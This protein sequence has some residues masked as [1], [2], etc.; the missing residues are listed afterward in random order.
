MN[1]KEIKLYTV[2]NAHRGPELADAAGEVRRALDRL[3]IGRGL[4]R[5]IEP[6]DRVAIAV[7]SRGIDR[8]SE[9]LSAL[10]DH[11]GA[12]GGSPFIVPAMGSHGGATSAGQAALLEKLGIRP[13]TV[14]A[15]VESSIETVK[16]GPAP[17]GLRLHFDKTAHGADHV[18]LVNRVKP[19]TRFAGPIQSG[20]CK[21][22]LVGLGNRAGAQELHQEAM[23]RP[24]EV[25]VA[26]AL[27]RLADRTPLAFGLG[28]V[29]NS[30]KRL[31]ALRAV[32]AADFE[33]ADRELLHLAD[34]WMAR[35]P[36]GRIDILVVDRIGKE[37]SG[38]GM[39]TNVIGRKE[40]RDAPRVLRILVRGLTRASR[41]NATG[42]GFAD[43]MIRPC[44]DSIDR[45]V[46]AL[47]CFTALRPEGARLPALFENDLSALEALLPTT[48]RR[49]ADEVRM[50]RIASTASLE[51]FQASEALLHESEN[52]PGI[53]F[54]DTP[55]RISFDSNGFLDDPPS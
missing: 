46:T 32:P 42:I 48:G 41:G 27:P 21:M 14:G 15:P 28:L 54:S 49:G 33:A 31:A 7:G 23:R 29:E 40:G 47:N 43:A 22:A 38:T 34:D 53:R 18:V 55:R 25:I 36:F 16:L 20:L 1:P 10:V 50:V 39:D 24:F 37:I 12:V 17:S 4:K 8:I 19:H 9:V 45:T 2:E 44:A 11:V 35:L 5:P 52:A 30:R 51:R 26:E 13:E 3:D 6:G